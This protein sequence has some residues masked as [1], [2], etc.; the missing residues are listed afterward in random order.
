MQQATRI[1][2]NVTQRNYS[3]IWRLTMAFVVAWS[4]L[5]L[6]PHQVTSVSS[7]PAPFEWLRQYG[8]PL[9]DWTESIAVAPSGVY[10]AGITAG[11]LPGQTNAGNTDAYVRKYNNNGNELWTRQ[12]GTGGGDEGFGIA[13]DA[14]GVYIAGHVEGALPG[15]THAGGRDVF[16]RK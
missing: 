7:S 6:S 14:S 5:A 8:T 12:F 15:Q 4:L 10:V 11:I 3:R 9:H 16:V 1:K 13:V 2:S